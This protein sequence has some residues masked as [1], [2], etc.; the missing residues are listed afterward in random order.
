MASTLPR[1]IGHVGTPPIKC[2]GIKTKLV[3][4]ITRSLKWPGEGGGRWIEPFMGSG[5]VALNLAPERALLTDANPHIINFYRS[6]QAGEINSD[7]VREFLESE[8]KILSGKGA[9]Y[10]YEVRER[11]N[12]DGSPLDFLFLNRACFNGLIRFNRRGK[13]NVP[14]NHKPQRFS[15]AYIT[16]ITNQVNWVAKQMQTRD[17]KFQV[18][19]WRETLSKAKPEDFVYMDPPYAGR[20]T[21]YFNAW[22][23]DEAESMA[24]VA[25]ELPCGL[26]V[27]MWLKNTYRN[28]DHVEECWPGFVV[29][30]FEHFYHVGSTES[31]R[32]K[33]TEALIIKPGFETFGEPEEKLGAYAQSALFE[34]PTNSVP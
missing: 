24:R 6:I 8:G 31:L 5:V 23:A 26:A 1:E 29:K 14:F 12:A 10:Y 17:I 16:K 27:S 32:N 3:P 18:A 21:D 30:E 15:K 13:F 34:H 11:F 9:A 7:K 19:D 2:Q 33:M 20:H 25:Q 22:G 4:F 28:N